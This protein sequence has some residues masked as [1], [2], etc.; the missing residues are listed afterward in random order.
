MVPLS[1]RLEEC[2]E[3]EGNPDVAA[4]VCGVLV[5]DIGFGGAAGV[6]TTGGTSVDVG[7]ARAP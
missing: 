7:P 6:G 3:G 4:A 1:L 5:V 2:R